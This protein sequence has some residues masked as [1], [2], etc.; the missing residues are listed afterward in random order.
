MKKLIALFLAL[1]V[2][3]PCGGYARGAQN[4]QISPDDY[5]AVDA[6]WEELNLA[7]SRAKKGRTSRSAAQTVAAAVEENE[8]YVDSTLRWQGE[9]HFTFETTAGVTC[10]YSTR[11]RNIA[12]NAVPEESTREPEIQTVS[13]G[14]AGGPE[15][16]LIEPYYGIDKNFTPQYQQQADSLAKAVGGTCHTYLRNEAT[17][18]AVANAVEK[19]SIV[20]FDSHGDTD[21]AK[22]PDYVSGAT[23]SYL[24]LQTGEGLTRADYRRDGNTYHAYNYGVDGKM[25]YYAVDGT[26]ISRHMKQNAKGGLVWMALCLG[27]AT[28]GLEQPLQDRGA[29]VVYGYSQEVTFD[30]DYAW[31]DVFWRE[32]KEKK[33]V[34]ESVASMK[35]EVGKWDYC[36]VYPT[37]SLARRHKCAFPIV[38]SEEDAY[39]GNRKADVLQDVRSSWV[40]PEACGH[41]ETK[42]EIKE[43]TCTESGYKKVFCA[44]CGK[45]LSF[46]EYPATGHQ[47]VNGVCSACGEEQPCAYYTDVH[48]GDWFYDGAVSAYE[49]DFMK[50]TGDSVF[51]PEAPM[52]RSMLAMAFYRKEGMPE[53]TAQ[54]APF[55]DVAENA[56]YR[57]AV[58]WAAEQ[59]I[60]NGA[61]DEKFLPEDSVTR[62]EVAAMLW[63]SSRPEPDA[64]PEPDF[65]DWQEVSDYAEEAMKWAVQTGIIRGADGKLKPGAAATR[66]QIAVILVRWEDF[67]QQQA[68]PA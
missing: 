20:F 55:T 35:E 15:I 29:S 11:V 51:A 53:S 30:F 22:G 43:P 23:T 65:P 38:V 26:C 50:G 36:N 2:L 62:E 21:Y 14:D 4:D 48:C 32:M 40:L 47:F 37:E 41:E 49:Q 5:L 57:D 9:D 1:T 27:M 68:V 46:E 13:Y 56:W 59:G 25:H 58:L 28:D 3:L 45:L 34:A 10:A 24:L 12:K 67:M 16:Y 7:E 64:A 54:E 52:T 63:R 66:A 18:D 44:L 19:G 60:V 8:L 61:G 42:T 31:G 33:T 6:M 39:P 17:I